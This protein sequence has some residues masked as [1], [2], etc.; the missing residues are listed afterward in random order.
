[1]CSN[2]ADDTLPGRG[3]PTAVESRQCAKSS[4]FPKVVAFIVTKSCIAYKSLL[5]DGEGA[6]SVKNRVVTGAKMKP[7]WFLRIML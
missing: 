3:I 1:M 5:N 4:Y 2:S 6:M 7:G